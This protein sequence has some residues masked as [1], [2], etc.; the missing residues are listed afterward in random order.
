MFQKVKK[1]IPSSLK[2]SLRKRFQ[3]EVFKIN[4]FNPALLERV[5][6][7]ERD[8]FELQPEVIKYT[9]EIKDAIDKEWA[10]DGISIP[11]NLNI[12]KHDYMYQFLKEYYRSST[13]AYAYYITSGAHM[14]SVLKIIAAKKWENFANVNSFL[15]FASG[16]G[17]LTR[18][19]I[20][21]I[22]PEQIWISDIK[23]GAINF[24]MQQFKVNGLLSCEDPDNFS[25]SRK[26]DFIFVGSLF[27]HLP[28][29]TF[30]RWLRLIYGM[31][32]EDG[33]MVFTVQ[34][35]SIMRNHDLSSTKG[36]L[37]YSEISEEL[38]LLSQDGRLPGAQYGTA[39]VDETFLRQ[40]ISKLKFQNVQYT[41]FKK[42]MWQLQDLYI[43]SKNAGLFSNLVF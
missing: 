25:M 16:Y 11:L 5:A 4:G 26:F 32:N 21:L 1:I 40:E 19:A 42:G 39:Y 14:M 6:Q 30:G 13:K 35:Q 3:A 36:K 43:L 37:I 24:Q 28:E 22:K 34:D 31:L 27:S 29:E 8:V 15:D 18:Y 12:S 20:E 23:P 10:F 9:D 38:N 41:R 7:L 2:I 17:R 33:I